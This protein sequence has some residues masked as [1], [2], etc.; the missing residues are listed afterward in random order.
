MLQSSLSG[1]PSVSGFLGVLECGGELRYRGGKFAGNKYENSES[2]RT[3]PCSSFVGLRSQR[4]NVLVRTNKRR[5]WRWEAFVAAHARSSAAHF[6]IG[7]VA[8]QRADT[9]KQN[10]LS[11]LEEE[12]DDDDVEFVDDSSVG[13]SLSQ[14][15]RGEVFLKNALE[16]QKLQAERRAAFNHGHERQNPT[17]RVKTKVLKAPEASCYGCGAEIQCLNPERPGFISSEIFEIVCQP[18]VLATAC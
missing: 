2:R 18:P 15:S 13:N 3:G 4:N 12:D 10:S 8:G 6:S 7:H 5:W 16:R 9:N 14:P 17:N 11:E 1:H